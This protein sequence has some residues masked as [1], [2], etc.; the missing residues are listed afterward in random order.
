[1][2]TK[3]LFSHESRREKKSANFVGR[4]VRENVRSKLLV[5]EECRLSRSFLEW[6]ENG[7]VNHGTEDMHLNTPP[8]LNTPPLITNH[9]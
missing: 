6:K 5:D 1:M 7:Q 9:Y 3:L 2:E 8:Y 4:S